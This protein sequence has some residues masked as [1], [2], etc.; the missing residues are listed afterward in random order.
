MPNQFFK[1][2]T[3]YL[4]DSSFFFSTQQIPTDIE[5]ILFITPEILGEIKDPMN[6]IRID[7]LISGK[8]LIIK[9]GIES[10]KKEFLEIFHQHSNIRRLSPA[11]RSLIILALTLKEKNL[12]KEIIV[13]TD[14]YEIQN[15]SKILKINVV[16]CICF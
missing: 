14:D 7:S 13:V 4:L 1:E 3:I 5:G 12:D 16:S 10:K 2:N 15:V 8:K 6:K 11:D 9:S